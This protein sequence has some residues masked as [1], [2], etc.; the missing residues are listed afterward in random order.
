MNASELSAPTAVIS[1]DLNEVAEWNEPENNLP[2][3]KKVARLVYDCHILHND[4]RGALSNRD[5][6]SPLT[7]QESNERT[8]QVQQSDR[9][10]DILISTDPN[11]AT[12]FYM[13]NQNSLNDNDVIE[14]LDL[15]TFHA[16]RNIEIHILR[17]VQVMVS[18]INGKLS[19]LNDMNFA[20]FCRSLTRI[21]FFSE[22]ALQM[23]SQINSTNATR[24]VPNE[25]EDILRFLIT[26]NQFNL[27]LFHEFHER[28]N[29]TKVDRTIIGRIKDIYDYASKLL[30][31]NMQNSSEVRTPITFQARKTQ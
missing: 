5:T 15:I 28:N 13:R 27:S 25:M 12:A 20:K 2:T 9:L 24:L 16:N 30:A 11:R 18:S 31:H 1:F 22:A 3:Q 17:I 8:E 7:H 21:K 29:C 10:L 6:N 23:A 14:L 19:Q 26:S 4:C